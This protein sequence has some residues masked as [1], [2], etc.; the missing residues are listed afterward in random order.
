MKNSS[1]FIGLLLLNSNLLFSQLAI[2]N[3]GS[4][5]DNAAMLD[6][7]SSTL[8]L[9]FPR[10][11]NEARNSLPSPETGLLIYNTSDNLIT[12][13]Y[14]CNIGKGCISLEEKLDSAKI[15]WIN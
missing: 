14:E 2:N 4:S 12:S 10:L 9:L 1:F 5:P 13:C 3:D 15:I 7:K 8:G 6:V 11:S